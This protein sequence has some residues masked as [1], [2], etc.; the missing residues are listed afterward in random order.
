[1]TSLVDYSKYKFSVEELRSDFE[2]FMVLKNIKDVHEIIE[3][4][5]KLVYYYKSGWDMIWPLTFILHDENDKFI[6]RASVFILSNI[7]TFDV[8][9]LKPTKR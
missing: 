5:V 2:S 9:I 7:P 6:A 3:E 1:M 4:A 8:I